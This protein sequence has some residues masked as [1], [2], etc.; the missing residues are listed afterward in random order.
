M[1]KKIAIGV[2]FSYDENWVGGAYYILNII[3]TLN[4]LE[5]SKKPLLYI[6]VNKK[7]H[8]EMANAFHY[9]YLE[10]VVINSTLPFWKR[11]VNRGFRMVFKKEFFF[12][13]NN[14]DY[15]DLLFPAN[16]NPVFKSI[17]KKLFWISDFQ[18]KYLPHFFTESEITNRNETQK[19]I[20]N[21]KY[22]LFSSLS[23]KS[24]F[25]TYFPDSKI[26]KYVYSFTSILER[27]N[28]LKIENVLKKYNLEQEAYFFSP[29]QFWKH[30]NQFVILKA[31]KK[32]KENQELNFKVYFSGK[33]FDYRNP[34]YFESLVKFVN[35]NQLTD[36]VK[37]LGFIDRED[38]ICFM[39]NAIA[40]IQPSLFEGWST[41]VEDAKALNQNCIVSNIPVHKEQLLDQAYFFDPNDVD[42]LLEQLVKVKSYNKKSF[43]FDYDEKIKHNATHFLNIMNTIISNE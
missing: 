12:P 1:G 30:K 14:F 8:F 32:L 24:D 36:Y 13:K 43:N 25:D 6:L 5:D 38:Q 18:E 37:F 22:L 34:D 16:F 7:E 29:N 28:D 33:E 27:N 15:I 31:L 17:K 9:P 35:E 26:Q 42:S 10:C 41:V 20:S 4:F 21:Q 3:K 2:Y 19:I 39:E 23:A 11:A 40:I